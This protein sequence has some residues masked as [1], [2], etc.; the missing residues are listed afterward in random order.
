MEFRRNFSLQVIIR[1][2]AILFICLMLGLIFAQPNW[3]FSNIILAI[4][5]F[6]QTIELI[7]FLNKTN[8]DITSFFEAID[9]KEYSVSYKSS[10]KNRSFE[11]LNNQLNASLQEFKNSKI[12]QVAQ[13]EYLKSVINQVKF[14]ILTIQSD[15]K[16]QMINNYAKELLKINEISTI[17]NLKKDREKFVTEILRLENNNSKIVDVLIENQIRQFHIYK[18]KIKHLSTEI[19]IVTFQDLKFEIEQKEFEAWHKLIRVLTHEIMNSVT[20]ISS[21]AETTLMVLQDNHE[22]VLQSV[23]ITNNDLEDIHSSVQTILQ[24]SD[25]LLRFIESYRKLLKIPKPDKEHVFVKPLIDDILSLYKT[26]INEKQVLIETKLSPENAT[27]FADKKLLEQVF[28]NIIKNSFEAL[29]STEFPKIQIGVF[30]NEHNTM[31]E[32]HDNGIGIE[33]KH[34]D[35]IFIPFFSTKEKGSGI[36]LS[37]SRQIMHLHNGE[38]LLKSESKKGTTIILSFKN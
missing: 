29:E 10:F 9:F 5:L 37:L 4:L 12:E 1:V 11:S 23:E 14:G 35:N 3:I 22:K 18:R 21:L 36:G 33:E 38:I 24:R 6:A 31:I 32:F 13:Y 7:R 19:E 20:P 16:L 28:I 15:E 34:M 8:R 2:I 26:Q 30:H 17:E 25:G 27:I